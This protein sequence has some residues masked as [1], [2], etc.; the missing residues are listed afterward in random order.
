MRAEVT[1]LVRRRRDA[2]LHRAEKAVDAAD[3]F[4]IAS[5]RLRRLVPF[6][7]ATW[8]A[9]DPATGLP[10]SPTRV[11]DLDTTAAQCSAQWEGEF[12]HRDV[13]AFVDLARARRPAGGLLAVSGDPATSRRYRTLLQ[14]L[15]YGDEMRAVLR[16]GGRPWGL[17]SLFRRE[18]EPAFSARETALVADLSAPLAAALRAHARPTPVETGGPPDG[19]GVLVFD[20]GGNLQ[21]VDDRGRAWIDELPP[22]RTLHSDL[23][24]GLPVWLVAA[25]FR[26]GAAAHGQ[27]DGVARVRVRSRRGRWLVCHASCQHPPAGPRTVVVVVEPASP[28]EIL[29]LVLDAYGLT[30][31]EREITALI[32]RGAG[33]TEIADGLYLSPHT[34]RGYVKTIFH[35]ADASSRGELV[36]KLFA[37]NYELAYRRTITRTRTG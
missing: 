28:A 5:T 3:V 37:E 4:D 15:G 30:E 6:A 26:A 27:G 33:T 32:V 16:A 2:L 29:P 14:P 1:S 34:V 19:P 25:V 21:S 36:A 35:K 12:V 20:V 24:V 22:D 23:G 7:A 9:T 18:G 8:S 10:T 17:V 31:R 13:N 11:D